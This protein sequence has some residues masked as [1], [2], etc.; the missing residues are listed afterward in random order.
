MRIP[1][2]GLL[3]AVALSSCSS[4]DASDQV[5][6]RSDTTAT[7]GS[8]RVIVVRD[9]GVRFD[10][11]P[12]WSSERVAVRVRVGGDAAAE[13]PGAEYLVSMNYRAEQPGR[14]DASLCRF[15][16]YPRDAWVRVGNE[17][18]P[19]VGTPIDSVGAWVYVLSL[20]QANPYPEGSLDSDQ[21]EAMRVTLDD[22]RSAFSIEGEGPAAAKPYASV[23]GTVTYR[24][25][26]ALAPGAVLEVRLEEVSR[27]DAPATLVGVHRNE[28][29]GP[30][31]IPF[32]VRFDPERIDT[33]GRYS[34]RATLQADGRLLW[35]TD[36]FV[37]VLTNGS[38][39][40][41]ELVLTRVRR[42]DE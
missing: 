40:H 28:S 12:T 22:V 4:K 13:Y 34:L 23:T 38:P 6:V 1:W 30:V 18:G 33:H 36:T 35:T 5:R 3:V 32:E 19:P 2:I 15:I 24:E 37:P 14:V 42:P 29:P 26:V 7:S 8:S 27:A 17:P 39:S 16:V 20:P 31:P 21:F 9:A 41:V 25:R 11:P 10:R